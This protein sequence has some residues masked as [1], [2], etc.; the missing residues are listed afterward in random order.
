[1]RCSGKPVPPGAAFSWNRVSHSY[2]NPTDSMQTILCVDQPKFEQCFEI[3]LP[4][5]TFS[6]EDEAAQRVE[7]HNDFWLQCMRNHTKFVFP[8]GLPEQTVELVCGTELPTGT[9]AD[10][11]LVFARGTG[12]A[13]GAD[14]NLTRNSMLMV[15]ASPP[16]VDVPVVFVCLLYEGKGKRGICV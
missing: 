14:G 9:E 2:E 15:R 3:E 5:A 13:V 8:G 12:D 6:P 11:V 4:E 16:S 7:F 1:M 10:A